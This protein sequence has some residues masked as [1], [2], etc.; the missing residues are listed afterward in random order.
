MIDEKVRSFELRFSIR[1]PNEYK[2]VK[3]FVG[4]PFRV[5]LSKAKALR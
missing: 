4:Q 5:A 3:C 2:R 1:T